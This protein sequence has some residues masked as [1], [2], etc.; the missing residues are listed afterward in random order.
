[1]GW[2]SVLKPEG[3]VAAGL[4]TVGLVWGV[5]NLNIGNTSNAQATDA[6]HPVMETSRRKA[7]LTALVT[8][9][10]LTLITK[11]ANVGIL[12]SGAIIAMELS[13]RHGIM[14]HPLS[15]QLQ[16]PNPNAAYEPA[17]NVIPMYNQG[18]PA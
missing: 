3:S 8:V 13:Y 9:A 4:A 17:E 5:Y 14:A 12:G 7:G 16:N 11:D 6:N 1:M 2:K 10:A 18:Q 15:G